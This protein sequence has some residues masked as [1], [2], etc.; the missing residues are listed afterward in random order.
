MPAVCTAV[1]YTRFCTFWAKHVALVYAAKKN[2]GNNYTAFVTLY[3]YHARIPTQARHEN[4][5]GGGYTFW[6]S[7]LGLT[8]RAQEELNAA[9]PKRDSEE[10]ST[11]SSV[12]HSVGYSKHIPNLSVKMQ[13]GLQSDQ[14]RSDSHSGKHKKGS[15]TENT[16]GIAKQEIQV[17]QQSGK[18]KWVCKVKTHIYEI[19]K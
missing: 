1:D 16:N 15:Q 14:H 6:G 17:G 18:H 7:G 12:N 13:M 11:R 10:N 4:S 2:Q 19:A 3:V 9:H 8:H 5:I